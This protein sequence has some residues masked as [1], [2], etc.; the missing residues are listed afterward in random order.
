MMLPVTVGIGDGGQW[1]S[2]PIG[3]NQPLLHFLRPKL[4]PGLSGLRAVLVMQPSMAGRDTGLNIHRVGTGQG[5]PG[6]Q[7]TIF[8]E[9]LRQD[10]QP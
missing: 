3:V 10:L 1:W 2:I 5:I 7:H 8:H 9:V 4:C 6:R